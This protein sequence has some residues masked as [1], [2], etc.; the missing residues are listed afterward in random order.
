MNSNDCPRGSQSPEWFEGLGVAV[1]SAAKSSSFKN[2]G[3]KNSSGAVTIGEG[4]AF[5]HARVFLD[6]VYKQI[7]PSDFSNLVVLKDD[8]TWGIYAIIET[9]EL[10]KSC[11]TVTG[12]VTRL[13]LDSNDD[14]DKFFIRSTSVYLQSEY[15][16]LT[17]V[18]IAD[19]IPVGG[20]QTLELNGFVDGLDKGQQVVL[21]GLEVGGTE[22]PI[23]EFITLE[24]VEHE[25]ILGG[26]TRI[27]FSPALKHVYKRDSVSLNANVAPATHG[28]TVQEVLGSG[29]ATQ[30]YQTFNLKQPPLTHLS[31]PTPSGEESTLEARVNDLLWHEADTLLGRDPDDRI[32]VTRTNN[33]GETIIEFGNGDTG[34]RLPTGHDNVRAVYRKGIGTEGLVDAEQLNMLMSRPLGLKEVTNPHAST[35]AANPESRDEAQRNAPLTVLTL[36]RTVSL[37]DYEDFSRS[38]GGIAKALAVSASTGQGRTVFITVAGPDG[39]LIEKDSPVYENLLRA[40]AG[41]GDPLARFRVQSYRPVTFRF[42]GKVKIDSDFVAEKVLGE[43]DTAIRAAFSFD[44]REFGQPVVLSEVFSVIQAIPGIVAVDVDFLYRGNI[45]KLEPRIFAEVPVIKN[46]GQMQAAELLTLHSGPLDHLEMMA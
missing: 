34:A 15:L 2:S 35:G 25:L 9:A 10:T 46:N 22:N 20:S 43:V 16:P 14:F 7:S 5:P 6:N 39:A 11:F 36:D 24:K 45:Q 41:A 31:A 23:S 33:A 40:L 17:R 8:K 12:K 42:G 28:E 29:D 27:T 30:S 3:T 21:S 19:P 32:F 38:F 26:C 1:K 4:D 18:P 37:Q 13:D 44:M